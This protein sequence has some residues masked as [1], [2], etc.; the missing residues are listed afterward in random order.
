MHKTILNL[1]GAALFGA[2]FAVGSLSGAT[3]AAA[4]PAEDQIISGFCEK[5]PV[6]DEC[7]SWKLHH[8]DWSEDQYQA[9]YNT[10]VG[11]AEFST[12]EAKE[13][14][15]RTNTD[16]VPG[17]EGN[18]AVAPVDPSQT[19]SKAESGAGQPAT[20]PAVDPAA[21]GEVIGDSP[22]H[23]ADCQASFKSYNPATDT[24]VG[25][26]GEVKKCKL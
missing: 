2:V 10:H 7:N 25:L 3:P 18:A 20:K 21:G 17:A 8:A 12:P 5:H 6:T 13:A 19:N 15:S 16:V 1:S 26:D 24:Y 23:V 11:T 9:F 22:N 4:N 14:F